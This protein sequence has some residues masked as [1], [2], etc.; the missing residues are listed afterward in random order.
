MFRKFIGRPWPAIMVTSLM[1]AIVH[2]NPEHWPTLFVLSCCMGYSYEKS[3]SL[4]RPIF[5]HIIF[6][7]ISIASTLYAA[8]LE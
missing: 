7:T 6:N 3:G 2:Q 1:F 5:I 8:G 4:Y